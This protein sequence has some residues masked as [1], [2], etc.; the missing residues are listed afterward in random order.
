MSIDSHRRIVLDLP[1]PG[2]LS[3]Y[4]P[5]ALGL[6]IVTST[7]KVRQKWGL[8]TTNDLIK[9]CHNLI[10][11]EL[12]GLIQTTINEGITG[13]IYLD[14][15]RYVAASSS[16]KSKS[17]DILLLIFDA[18]EEKEERESAEMSKRS[19][20]VFRRIGK[21]LTMHQT[22][23]ELCVLAVHE[24]ASAA[25]LAAM[26]LWASTG[27]DEKLTLQG[28]VGVSRQGAASVGTLDPKERLVCAAELVAS[29]RKPLWVHSVS[30]N[31]MTGQLEAKFCYLPAGSM[32]V[33]P[34]ISGDKVLGVIELIGREGDNTFAAS[35]AM[36]EVIAEH[37]TLALNT[38]FVFASM[39]R[40]ATYDPMTGVANHRALQDFLNARVSESDRTGS[41]IGVVMLDVDHFRAFNEEEGHDAGDFV[42]KKVA[43]AIQESIR[44]Y[45]LAA[46]YGGEEFSIVMPGLDLD[47][48]YEV[49][50]RIIEAIERIE[51]VTANGRV[52]HVTASAGCS[53]FPM[54]ARDPAGLLKA[55]DVALF[56]AKRAGRNCVKRYDGAFRDE[57]P[58][59]EAD[60]SWLEKW[61]NPTDREES[62]RLTKK[63]KPFL[64][65]VARGLA[66]SKNQVQILDQLVAVYPSYKRLMQMNN[67]EVMRK[68]EAAAEFRP[69]LPSLLT[70]NERF[71]GTGPM[72]MSGQKVPLL[73]RVMAVMLAIA[74]DN[75]RPL[76][77]DSKRF[78]PEIIAL[79]A[80]VQEAA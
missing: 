7:G 61:I 12:S 79:I 55:A 63:V 16:K 20:E 31:I 44:P 14:G 59:E 64:E 60:S 23:E 58:E 24:I 15:I 48:T 72:K 42:L 28:H 57:N 33:L 65:F 21:A 38:C 10:D 6:A 19:A 1:V 34:L 52:R 78:D 69:L 49:C 77:E 29:K 76:L 70:L 8:A 68:L 51:F 71:D 43:A 41:D 30:D 13:S 9:N 75:G 67:P 40:L 35:K 22:L 47:Y 26:L 39:E 74:E 11:S 2:V 53:S 4:D 5:T 18:S 46:R 3:S 45:D 56:K 50:E 32:Y 37:L 27:T 66:L 17:A 36:F 62:E 54:T 80:D 25:G 73:S